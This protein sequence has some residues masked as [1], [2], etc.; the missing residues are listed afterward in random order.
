MAFMMTMLAWSVADFGKFMGA[1]LPHTRAAMR[2]GA[3]YLLKAATATPGAL[4]VQVGDPGRDHA[5][6]E[7]PEDMDTP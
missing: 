6:W 4:Y 7:R 2:W 5:C 3:D 1:E